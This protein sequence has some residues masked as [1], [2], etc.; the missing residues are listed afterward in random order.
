MDISRDR[1]IPA[2]YPLMG[3]AGEQV[4]HIGSIELSVIAGE[5]LKQKL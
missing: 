4:F 5:H 1:I 3:F 2:K